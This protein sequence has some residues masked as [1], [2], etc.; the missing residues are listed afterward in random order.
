MDKQKIIIVG[1]ALAVCMLLL[2][3]V[4]VVWSTT[5]GTRTEKISG[6]TSTITSGDAESSPATTTDKKGD[7]PAPARA[8]SELNDVIISQKPSLMKDGQPNFAITGV[9][10][11]ESKW[12]IVTIHNTV[13]P[14]VG[15]AWVILKD[16]GSENGGLILVVGPG[17]SFPPS[18]PIPDSVRKAI[19]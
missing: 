8:T 10:R 16:E 1:S 6:K 2:A 5:E 18:V 4:F 11:V 13:D 12:Y 3:A 7:E 15:N 19:K 14:T 9:K 17:T